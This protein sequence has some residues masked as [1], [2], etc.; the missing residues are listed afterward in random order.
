[1]KAKWGNGGGVARINTFLNR[2]CSN[3]TLVDDLI[4]L[5]VPGLLFLSLF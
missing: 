3:I 5:V 1:M 4:T 2:L